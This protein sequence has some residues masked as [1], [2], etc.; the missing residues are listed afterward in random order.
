MPC[1]IAGDAEIGTSACRLVEHRDRNIDPALRPR[2]LLVEAAA[3]KFVVRH[4]LRDA[5]DLLDVTE[6]RERDRAELGIGLGVELHVV[7][8]ETGITMRVDVFSGRILGEDAADLTVDEIGDIRKNVRP[9]RGIKRRI[10][11]ARNKPR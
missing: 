6:R 8:I 9:Q 2:P 5:Q 4:Q 3:A 11:D 1:F 10:V 7:G